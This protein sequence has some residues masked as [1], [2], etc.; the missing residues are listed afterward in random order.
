MKQAQNI[1]LQY[2]DALFYLCS[3][4]Y[5]LLYLNCTCVTWFSCHTSYNTSVKVWSR[6]T[7]LSEVLVS[8]ELTKNIAGLD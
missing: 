7:H 6:L 2:Q 5:G 4:R 1:A 3:K 8:G